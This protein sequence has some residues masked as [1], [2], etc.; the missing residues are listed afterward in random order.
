[1][2]GS[3]IIMV[4]G[5]FVRAFNVVVVVVVVVVDASAALVLGIRAA[6]RVQMLGFWPMYVAGL[7][8]ETYGRS[9]MVVSASFFACLA[10]IAVARLVIASGFAIAIASPT[11]V[12]LFVSDALEFVVVMQLKLVAV[13][14]TSRLADLVAVFFLDHSVN[15]PRV[16][17][18]LKIL[19]KS[20]E[21][22]VNESASAS[23]VLRAITLVKAHVKPLNLQSRVG[24]CEISRGKEFRDS[25]HL[26]ESMK[27]VQGLHHE[28]LM[29]PMIPTGR[30]ID[31][32]AIPWLLLVQR[33]LEEQGDCTRDV[34]SRGAIVC[35]QDPL[36][37]GWLRE[38]IAEDLLP[39]AQQATLEHVAELGKALDVVQVNS[40]GIREE[41]GNR[42]IEHKLDS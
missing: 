21:R 35:R 28:V 8:G 16:V 27:M 17:N 23:D 18:T 30:H 3:S 24:G 6:I 4:V 38:V 40:R 7:L 36:Q 33:L 32:L 37:S 12:C 42:S 5:V 9:L 29:D 39:V 11:V 26:L 1:M 15:N 34:F 25:Q 31:V 10:L 14:T 2:T 41:I 22:F 13:V 20:R 19:R